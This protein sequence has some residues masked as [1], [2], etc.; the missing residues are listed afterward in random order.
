M[1]KVRPVS[2]W[3]SV[4][5]PALLATLSLGYAGGLAA[6]ATVPTMTVVIINNSCKA[7][8]CPAGQ[9]AKNI[10][11]VLSMGPSDKDLYMRAIM[12]V[13]QNNTTSLFPLK[14][15]MRFY[16]NPMGN[17]IPPGGKVTVTLPF[18]TQLVANPDPTKP[19]QYA[20]WWNGGRIEIFDSEASTGQPSAALTAAFN[21]EKTV[22]TPVAG[23]AVPTLVCA[24]P[25]CQNLKF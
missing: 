24:P 16:I 15:Q 21:A 3:R 7:G 10:Y 11:P 1:M 18:Y 17:G 6:A 4:I 22:V 20:N 2:R 5:A 13:P 19:N 8:A 9:T 23:A 25:P 14:G 12:N